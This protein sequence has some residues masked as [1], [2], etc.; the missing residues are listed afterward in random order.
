MNRFQETDGRQLVILS[1]TSGADA[2]RDYEWA[3]GG[4]G[5][6]I[7]QPAPSRWADLGKEL[8]ERQAVVLATWLIDAAERATAPGVVHA[9]EDWP[10]VLECS[11][12]L[13]ALEVIRRGILMRCRGRCGREQ[14]LNSLGVRLLHETR[15]ARAQQEAGEN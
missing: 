11:T 14:A 13:D 5:H 1:P 6:M 10:R 7:E 8:E 3:L 9:A 12:F 15:A 4:L 2:L